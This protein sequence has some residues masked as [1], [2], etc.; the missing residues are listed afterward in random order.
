MTILV[1]CQQSI[2]F[3]E[4]Q[5]IES[6][7]I[8]QVDQF[9]DYNQSTYVEKVKEMYWNNDD[10]ICI[11]DSE[12]Y[13]Y[14]KL[15]EATKEGVKPVSKFQLKRDSI[16]FQLID[17]DNALVVVSGTLTVVLTDSTKV[18]YKPYFCSIL[19]RKIDTNWKIAYFQQVSKM[20]SNPTDN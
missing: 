16:K 2:N 7:L 15:M 10:F 4:K 18:T 1:S 6:E 13:S 17:R 5:I 20:T 11:N 9:F 19:F 14:N 12:S 8:E 3:E